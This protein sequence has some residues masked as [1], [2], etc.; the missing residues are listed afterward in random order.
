MLHDM[1]EDYMFNLMKNCNLIRN[2]MFCGHLHHGK[3]LLIDMLI[4]QCFMRTGFTKNTNKNGSNN[5][6]SVSFNKSLFKN[7]Q[8]W[9]L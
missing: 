8:G 9:D 1:S 4:Q 5:Q 7:T 3:T 2:V 6:E